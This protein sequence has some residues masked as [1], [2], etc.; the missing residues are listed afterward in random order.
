LLLVVEEDEPTNGIPWLLDVERHEP[1]GGI[2]IRYQHWSARSL[3]ASNLVIVADWVIFL[4]L[5]LQLALNRVVRF[6]IPHYNRAL[7]VCSVRNTRREL[8]GLADFDDANQ[9]PQI[10]LQVRRNATKS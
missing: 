10:G 4:E 2:I 3:P 1:L 6:L 9:Y 7:V 5:G 8:S